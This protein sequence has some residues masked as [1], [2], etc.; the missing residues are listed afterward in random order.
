[1]FDNS[2][3]RIGFA[4]KYLHHDQS[5]KSKILEDIQRAYTERCTTVAWLDR[6]RCDVAE[7]RLWDIMHHNSAAA[8]RL[9]EYVG[10]LPAG[11]RMLRLGS[12]QLPMYTHE[13]WSQFWQ[14]SH[15]QDAAAAAYAQVGERARQLDVRM[16]MHPGPFCVLASDNPDIVRRSIDEF[17]YHA[18]LIRW[19]GYGQQFQDFKCNVHISGRRGPAGLLETLSKLSPEA[20]RTITI[21]NDENSW[22]LDASLELA[23]VVPLV[24]DVHHH[25]LH[26]EGEY[27]QPHDSRVARVVESWRGVR[28]VIHYSISRE[29][30]L[31]GHDAT[32]LLDYQQ[33]LASGYKKARM[34]AHSESCWNQATN[35]WVLEFLPMADIM[36]EAKQKN[37]ASSQLY[38]QAL[39]ITHG[40]HV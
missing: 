36:T 5:L 30:Y 31:V 18:D 21:E 1:M 20:R 8:L 39:T 9:V 25:F 17:E 14:Q 24:L 15:V 12:N 22:G 28:P 34:R 16:S 35:N 6:Q 13:R 33:L 38:A 37:L 26:S 11:Q 23:D 7:Q 32:K 4:C 29:D 2:V 40:S 27:I 10:S 19:M 3:Q